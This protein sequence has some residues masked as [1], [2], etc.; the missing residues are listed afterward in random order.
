MEEQARKGVTSH[1]PERIILGG[2]GCHSPYSAQP[3]D[4]T[5]KEVGEL[6]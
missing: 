1:A 5:R 2:L 3:G 4:L 6:A